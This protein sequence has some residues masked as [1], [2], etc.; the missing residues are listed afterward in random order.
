MIAYFDQFSIEM[1]ADQA[2]GAHHRGACD[3]DVAALLCDTKIRA[4]LAKIS[5]EA[6]ADALAE[7]GAWSEDELSDADENDARIVWI[8]AGNI[9]DD[10]EARKKS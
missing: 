5:P 10:L 9:C 8:A 7:L 1:T 4:Q 6:I 3:D 2:R